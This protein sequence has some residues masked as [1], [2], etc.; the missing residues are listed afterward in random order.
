[1]NES[2]AITADMIECWDGT[3]VDH[4]VIVGHLLVADGLA[5]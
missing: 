1:M 2:L 4:G 3:P 5:S